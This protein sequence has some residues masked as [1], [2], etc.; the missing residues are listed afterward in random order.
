MI[1]YRRHWPR[2]LPGLLILL[3]LATA[4][5][6]ATF[7]VTE[8]DS[9]GW[10]LFS[11]GN[12]PTAEFSNQQAAIGSGSYR[13]SISVATSEQVLFAPV[14]GEALAD[15]LPLTYDN[16]RESGPAVTF[17][18]ELQA[19]LDNNGFCDTLF[20]FVTPSTV[21]GAWQSINASD[22]GW[23]QKTGDCFSAGTYTSVALSSV[24]ATYPTARVDS[25]LFR[26]GDDGGS[27]YIGWTGYLDNV[28]LGANVY[29]FE[30]G[31]TSGEATFCKRSYPDLGRVRVTQAV[32]GYG[33][34]G[35]DEIR[36]ASDAAQLNVFRDFD[37][38]GA[39]EFMI[40]D[41]A[42]VDDQEWYGLFLGACDPVYVPASAVTRIR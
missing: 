37:G 16:Y 9:A 11:V 41:I 22:T 31:G 36:R 7:T 38:S 27:A 40:I 25:L 3:V 5:Y 8:D 33:Q 28:R 17:I 39:D 35:R 24:L 32:Y 26:A 21:V 4:V 42:T 14:S 18:I 30:A 23:E 13:V 2:L 12:P 19:D 6:A 20:R 1:N 15:I 10:M 34:P 29:D